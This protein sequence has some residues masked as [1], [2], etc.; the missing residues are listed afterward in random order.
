VLYQLAVKGGVIRA[1]YRDH[2]KIDHVRRIFGNYGNDS[3]ALWNRIEWIKGDILDYYS[4][5]EHLQGIREVYHA[6]GMVS[7]N[8]RDKKT[9][10]QVNIQGTANVVNACLEKGV[11]RLCYVSSIATLGEYDGNEYIDENFLWSPGPNASAYAISKLKGEMEVWRGI[12]EGLQAVIV[13]PS[14][15]VGPGMW[16]GSARLLL[17][18]IRKGLK[19]YPVGSS[20]Y[21]DVRDVATA[22][23]KLT[24]GNH[25]NERYIISAENIMH[26]IFLNQIADAMHLPHPDHPLT[27][28]LIRMAAWAEKLRSAVAATA[29]RITREA[30]EIA[31]E[32]LAYSNKKFRETIAMDFIA[33]EESVQLSVALFL[34]DT[35]S[36]A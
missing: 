27:N 3:T 20:G 36:P 25:F 22:M 28:W 35:I 6:A 1:L 16:M 7:F 15:I 32:K 18:R 23:I 30:L 9:L 34:K 8:N 21:V 31:T 29:P 2:D 26:R 5:M 4:L 17:D 13:N 11:E 19:Y 33:I 10:H 12:H 24:E 14:V